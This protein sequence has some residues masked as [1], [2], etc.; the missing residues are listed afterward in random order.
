[1][2]V[3]AR[4]IPLIM[5]LVSAACG[6]TRQNRELDLVY[7]VVTLPQGFR[8][9][10]GVGD[11]P[12]GKLVSRDGKIVIE[13]ALGFYAGT[14]AS[15]RQEGQIWFRKGVVDDIPYQASLDAWT[16]NTGALVKTLHITFPDFGPAN[17]W[18]EVENEAEIDRITKLILELKPQKPRKTERKA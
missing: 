18:S 13:F 2:Q 3:F 5:F 1:M 6:T 14:Y 11:T 10:W 9:E 12:C 7:A 4:Y 17:F 15:P 8:H 16:S